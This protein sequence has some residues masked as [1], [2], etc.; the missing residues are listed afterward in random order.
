MRRCLT[1]TGKMRLV[2]DLK[3]KKQ[4]LAVALSLKGR[5]RT[6]SRVIGLCLFERGKGSPVGYIVLPDHK[7]K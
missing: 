4:D 6:T 7:I 2:T 5:A 1:R 3:E